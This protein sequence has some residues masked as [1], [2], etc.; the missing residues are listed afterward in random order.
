MVR[1]SHFTRTVTCRLSFARR[2]AGDC[3]D[4]AVAES[5]FATLKNDSST[6]YRLRLAVRPTTQSRSTSRTTTTPT[7]GIHLSATSAQFISNSATFKA[8][9][10]RHNPL[11]RKSGQV[12]TASVTSKGGSA[13][14]VA[15]ESF[16]RAFREVDLREDS[17]LI[18][19]AFYPQRAAI[20]DMRIDHGGPYISV[21]QQFLDR[22]DVVTRF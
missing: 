11:S 10:P 5:F 1:C 4:N 22:A 8:K 19:G 17:G 3:W 16:L 18:E 15:P 14:E 9:P 20:N 6:V 2:E 21:P 12:H 13:R 7:D